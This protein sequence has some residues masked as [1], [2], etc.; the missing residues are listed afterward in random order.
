M[1]TLLCWE[2]FR[3]ARQV[4]RVVGMWNDED[5]PIVNCLKNITTVVSI[6]TQLAIHL[7]V[8]MNVITTRADVR[9]CYE[10]LASFALVTV[11]LCKRSTSFV[12][13]KAFLSIIQD[14]RSP[15]F[16]SHPK[17]YTTPLLNGIKV[18]KLIGTCYMNTVILVIVF[19]VLFSLLGKHLLAIPVTVTI[20]KFF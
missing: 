12:H 15:V 16:N 18:M 4:M 7:I 19:Y 9:E 20:G 11:T 6:A 8:I 3:P 17:K 14:L 2:I 13:K 10:L 5:S 1:T